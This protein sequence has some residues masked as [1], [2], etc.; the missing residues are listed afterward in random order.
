MS[1][2]A[3]GS[4]LEMLVIIADEHDIVVMADCCHVGLPFVVM[5]GV[6]WMM[7]C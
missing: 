1:S 3:I 4:D 6:E 7:R 5:S 2:E